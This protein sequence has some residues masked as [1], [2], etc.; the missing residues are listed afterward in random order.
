MPILRYLL[1]PKHEGCESSAR[2]TLKIQ[3]EMM[4]GKE[5]I[6][7]LPL[8]DAIFKVSCFFFSA[9]SLSNLI[10]TLVLYCTSVDLPLE[11]AWLPYLPFYNTLF[12]STHTPYRGF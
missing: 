12:Q 9:R 7:L 2:H 6:P 11:T 4:S 10:P 5:I 3:V 1:S 8:T